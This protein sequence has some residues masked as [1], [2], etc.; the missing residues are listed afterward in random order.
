MA[1]LGNAPVVGDSTNSFRLLDDIASFTLTFDAT[2]TSVVSISGDTLSFTNHRFVTGQKVTYTDGGGTAIGGLTD[3]TSYFIIKVDQ[4]TIK[5]AT[6]A[7][8]AASSTAIN[9]TSGAAGGSHTLNVKFDGVNTK[10]KATHSNGTK[11]NVSR[12]GQISLSINGVIQQPQETSS[13]TVGYSIEADSTIVFSTAPAAT[14]KVFA[15]FIGEVAASFDL[16]DNTIDNFTGDG[17]TTIFNLSKEV[18]SSQDVLVTLDGVTQYPSDTSTTRS[19]SVVNQALTFVSAPDTGV[20]IQARHIG[21]AGATSSEV[22]GFYGRTGNVAL[23]STDDVS[24]QNI[25]GVGATFT[26]NVNIEGVLTYEDVTNVDSIG[27][28]TARAGVLVGSGI[29]LSKDGD[30]FATGVTTTGSLVSNGSISVTGI[31]TLNGNIFLNQSDPKIFFNDGGSMISNANVANTLAFFSDGST[32]RAR[33]TSAGKVGVGTVDPARILH[34]HESSSD[35]CQLHITNSTTGTSGSDGVSFA[36]GSDE[37]LIINQRENNDILLKTADT[38]RLRINSS[39]N[40]KLPDNGKLQFGGSLSSGNGDLQIYHDS[41][42]SYI[43]DG[44]GTG[45]LIFKSNTYSFRNAADD[46]QIATFNENGAVELYYDNTKTFET[47]SGGASVTGDFE[48]SAEF[49]MTSGGNKNRFFDCSLS[50][51]EGLHIRST[52]GGDANHENMAVFVRNGK[53]EL[54]HDNVA[55]VETT[56]EGLKIQ[57]TASGQTAR[58]SIESTN[59]GQAGIELKTSLSG[60]NRA[61]RID[62]YNQNTLQWTIFNDYNQSGTNDFSIRH[63]AEKAIVALPDGAVELYHDD[64]QVFKTETYGVTLV[65]DKALALDPWQGRLDRGWSDFPSISISPSTT[66]GTQTEFRVHGINGSL[67]GYGSGADFSIDFRIDGSYQQGSDQRRKTNIEE[68]TGALDTVKQ[69]T[70]KKFNIINRSGELD[71]NKGAQKQFGLIAQ[72]CKDIIPEVI[73]FHP[74][75]DTPNE[76]GWASAY[77]LDYS[78]LTPLLIN[79]VK[80]LSAKNDA[81]E[82]RIA[83]LEG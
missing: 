46:E 57:K 8:N 19:Y 35:T 30:I 50:D 2:D 80:E 34:L 64:T 51:G 63:G 37:S 47:V 13:P 40:V 44:S 82:A 48:I 79:A 21:F 20:A 15:T 73:K 75:E 10:F 31:S 36:L 42:N 33:I 6:N 23:K 56:A 70:G 69:L 67:V 78:Q 17:S 62:M 72:E 22:T 9:L 55:S 53:C 83:A 18:P 24:V 29:T 68:I 16:T 1:Y 27:I 26:S 65:G 28:V 54:Y 49:N 41:N 61:S 71:P 77:G 5:L 58:L 12:A 39:G 3:G 52:Q 59:G 81:L 4:N 76:N 25:S 38:D 43:D 14:D 32:E 7:S 45:A 60:T 11:A 66:Y 74:D